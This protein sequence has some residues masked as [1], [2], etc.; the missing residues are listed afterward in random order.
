MPVRF[1][2]RGVTRVA[3]SPGGIEFFLWDFWWPL[4]SFLE[5]ILLRFPFLSNHALRG[6]IVI[7]PEQVCYVLLL[8]ESADG[9]VAS[10]GR[11]G[12]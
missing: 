1:F 6:T 4:D 2:F 7:T 9:V 10:Q 5:A 3:S 11:A 12:I 8:F